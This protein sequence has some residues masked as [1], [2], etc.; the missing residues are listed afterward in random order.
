V[1]VHE[2]CE[3]F[4]KGKGL[5]KALSTYLTEQQGELDDIE[6]GQN[7]PEFRIV[8]PSAPD[9]AAPHPAVDIAPAPRRAQPADDDIPFEEVGPPVR[10]HRLAERCMKVR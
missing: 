2:T 3:L 9:T 4:A 1:S 5:E 6:A 10:V 8:A 7:L